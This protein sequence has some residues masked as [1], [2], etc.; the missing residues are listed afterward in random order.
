MLRNRHEVR[1][2]LQQ[3]G[4]HPHRNYRHEAGWQWPNRGSGT[5]AE[6]GIGRR[7]E[8]SSAAAR[9]SSCTVLDWG[10]RLPPMQHGCAGSPRA[11]ARGPLIIRQRPPNTEDRS[12]RHPATAFRHPYPA[13]RPRGPGW[14]RRARASA[15]AQPRRR[16]HACRAASRVLVPTADRS[17][18]L[19]ADAQDDEGDREPDEWVGGVDTDRHGSGAGDNRQTDVGV[20]AGVVAVGN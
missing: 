18:R 11:A 2:L 9:A 13:P 8:D 4:P 7:P 6:A 12:A 3:L 19:P 17:P 14:A 15:P 16:T 5:A 1:I 10:H 20:G